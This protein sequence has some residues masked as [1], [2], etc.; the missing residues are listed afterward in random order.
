MDLHLTT[1]YICVI[2]C[3][4]E[5]ISTMGKEVEKITFNGQ[6]RLLEILVNAT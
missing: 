3:R 4:I 2:A 1:V 5:D 6:T